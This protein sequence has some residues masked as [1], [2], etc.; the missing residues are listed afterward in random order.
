MNKLIASISLPYHDRSISVLNDGILVDFIIED[1][2]SRNKYDN[3]FPLLSLQ[4]LKDKY[5]E[6]NTI[7]ISQVGDDFNPG[8]PLIEAIKKLNIKYN[9]LITLPVSEHHS[10]HASAGFYSSG[11]EEAGILVIDGHGGL[12]TIKHEGRE[13]FGTTTTS[14]WKGSYA[15]GIEKKYRKIWYLPSEDNSLPDYLLDKYK[16]EED[17]WSPTP[18]IGVMY[19]TIGMHLGVPFVGD[20]GKVMG[21][22]SYGKENN[23]P[24]FLF[25]DTI[26]C[27]PSV[28][29]NNYSLYTKLYPSLGVYSDE[30]RK[31]L[32]YNIQKSLEKVFLTRVEQ[33]LN[34]CNSNNLVLS[35]GCFLN[36]IG[37][38]L[39]KKNFPNINIFADPLA[40]DGNLS[41]GAAKS[42]YYFNNK[43]KVRDPLNTLFLGLSYTKEEILNS[44]KKYA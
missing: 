21:L 5:P 37:N 32:A 22:S 33:T 6:I 44:I 3:K 13:L 31:N 20:A 34:L 17:E 23:L 16:Q 10:L 8:D 12:D 4:T 28:I 14:I 29:K 15:E 41:L 2:I 9:K 11:F 26:E 19:T 18:D 30:N 39:I 27:N 36:V 35:G 25:E 40:N 7:L 1:R 43:S 38:Y 24:P 42:Y